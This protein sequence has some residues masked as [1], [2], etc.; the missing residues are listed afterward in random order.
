VSADVLFSDLLPNDDPRRDSIYHYMFRRVESHYM[1]QV[2][3]LRGAHPDEIVR[4]LR[5]KF[6]DDGQQEMRLNFLI[7]GG[8]VIRFAARLARF[9]QV[10]ALFPYLDRD[11]IDLALRLPGHLRGPKKPLLRKL[12]ERHYSPDLQRPG[13]V[14]FAAY[15]IEW[16]Q[17][18]GRLEPLLDLLD[19]QRTYDR[20]VYREKGLRRLLHSYRTGHP[21]RQWH[22]VLWQLVVFELFCR[23]FVDGDGLDLRGSGKRY[24]AG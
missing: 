5:E 12:A 2:V 4:I 16:L 7:E 22:L 15:P 23:Q 14:P 8:L 20:G 3:R 9:H 24:A 1:R 13:K 21:E 10:E 18:A 6:A 19:E 17:G 11:V